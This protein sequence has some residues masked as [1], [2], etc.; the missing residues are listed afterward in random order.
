MQPETQTPNDNA[1]RLFCVSQDANRQASCRAESQCHWE[2][3]NLLTLSSFGTSTRFACLEI[4]P[5]PDN[6]AGS[7]AVKDVPQK[8]RR[9]IS[10]FAICRDKSLLSRFE[11]ECSS[12]DRSNTQFTDT[13][14]GNGL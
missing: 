13:L 5:D 9:P 2:H 10:G 12:R 4:V 3:E 6:K 14:S 8:A 11:G 1:C 7:G